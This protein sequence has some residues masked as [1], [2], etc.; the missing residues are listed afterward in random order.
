MFLEHKLVS[1][2]SKDEFSVRVLAL[3]TCAASFPPAL[4]WLRIF[5]IFGHIGVTIDHKQAFAYF[6]AAKK[7]GYAPAM[8]PIGTMLI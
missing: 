3:M 7:Q 5:S 4:T 2:G 8:I 6:E 1:Y